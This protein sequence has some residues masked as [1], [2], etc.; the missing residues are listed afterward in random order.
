MT[1][2][3]LSEKETLNPKE[4]IELF[5]LRGRKFYALLNS[6]QELCFLAHFRSRKLII[7]DEFAKYYTE[8]PEL[9]R[10]EFYGNKKRKEKGF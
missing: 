5:G 3:L 8:H 10:G 7:W 9:E 4:T 6:N 2:L 1:K